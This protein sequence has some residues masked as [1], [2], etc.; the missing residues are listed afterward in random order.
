MQR[1]ERD[2]AGTDEERA[3]DNGRDIARCAAGQT[4]NTC[5]RR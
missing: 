2:E 5:G 1:D 4:R 3:Q